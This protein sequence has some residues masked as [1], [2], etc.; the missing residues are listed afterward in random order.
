MLFEAI[1]GLSRFE[2]GSL[3]AQIAYICCHSFIVLLICDIV[4]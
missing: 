2:V 4:F 3:L 1:Y